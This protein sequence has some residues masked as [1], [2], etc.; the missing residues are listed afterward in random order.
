MTPTLLVSKCST[1]LAIRVGRGN[2]IARWS[3]LDVLECQSSLPCKLQD[4][5]QEALYELAE[6]KV[7]TAR[8]ASAAATTTELVELGRFE[9][10]DQGSGTGASESEGSSTFHAL[11]FA[12]T[13][14]LASLQDL[15]RSDQGSAH[16]QTQSQPCVRLILREVE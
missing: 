2:Q 16:G 14:T 4:V 11:C 3:L 10:V 6:T 1:L 13:S 8:P 7:E 9:F 5:V 12:D 15:T